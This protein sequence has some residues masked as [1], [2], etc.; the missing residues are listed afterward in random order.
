MP[1]QRTKPM[2]ITDK[3]TTDML[4]SISNSRTESYSRVV[5]A[6]ILLNYLNN[7]PVS[8]IAT[9][10]NIDRHIVYRCVDKDL[11]FGIETA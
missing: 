6:N 11:Q 5:R 10:L 2:L 7:V 3:T 9:Q 1:F 4:T 8:S